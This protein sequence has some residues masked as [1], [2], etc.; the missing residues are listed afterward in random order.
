MC[1][2]QAPTPFPDTKDSRHPLPW[3]KNC[4]FTCSPI[5]ADNRLLLTACLEQSLLRFLAPVEQ[6]NRL[7]PG[8]NLSTAI[9][10]Y[11]HK[12]VKVHCLLHITQGAW[13]RRGS[14][15]ISCLSFIVY[16]IAFNTAHVELCLL[17]ICS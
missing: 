5:K 3:P 6:P 9:L 17:G 12:K 2:Y 8:C 13:Y 15:Q 1:R 10:L 11:V 7:Y 14:A 16:A 4:Q